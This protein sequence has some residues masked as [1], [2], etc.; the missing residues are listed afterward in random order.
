[1]TEPCSPRS[2]RTFQTDGSN[3]PMVVRALRQRAPDLHQE[4]TEHLR[5]ALPDVAAVN[6]GE[7]ADDRHLYLKLAYKSGLEL[8][9]W[10]LSE[11]TLRIIALTLIPFAADTDGIYLIEEPE[12]GV[13]PQAVEAVHQALAHPVRIQVVV[14]THSPV[15]VGIVDPN[16]LLCFSMR[17]GSTTAI[18][19]VEHPAIRAWRR[20]IDLG[21]LFASRVLE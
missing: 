10:R 17:D 15:F 11:G 18:P 16:D 8:P 7:R 19:G 14:A 21:T 6:I 20:D 12:N 13:H 9:A 1:M 2:L 3:L 4:W 5:E